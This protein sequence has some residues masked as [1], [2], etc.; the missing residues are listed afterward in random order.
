M[1]TQ[2][3]KTGDHVIW[4][5]RPQGEV[6]YVIPCTVVADTPRMSVL[7]QATGSICK[8]RTG[9]RGGPQ[10][11]N[12]IANGRS[13]SHQDHIWSGP[14]TVRLHPWGTAYS[15]I[16]VWDFAHDRAEGWYVNLEAAWQRTRLG[17]DSQDLVLDITVSP[18][19]SSWA[20]K[21]EDELEWSVKTGK[22]STEE[23]A[24]I[25]EAGRQAIQAIETRAWPFNADWSQWRPDSNWA[26]STLPPDWADTT[27]CPKVQLL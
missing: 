10:G 19:L 21:D 26:M 20:W 8:K 23:A 7:F 3:W 17:F 4:R 22:Y 16:R 18:D 2:F 13:S 15:I 27:D 6:G 14:P 5:S 12:L 1:S 24:Y 9:Q 11:R 25:R